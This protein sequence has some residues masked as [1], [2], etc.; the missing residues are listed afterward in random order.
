VTI[1]NIRNQ[2]DAR[3][4]RKERE[5]KNDISTVSQCQNVHRTDE[6]NGGKWFMHPTLEYRV[7]QLRENQQ[8]QPN[9]CF[10][11]GILQHSKYYLYYRQQSQSPLLFV[12]INKVLIKVHLTE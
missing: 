10:D 1:E 6:C 4:E 9:N 3:V 12:P 7:G 2:N 8:V 5:N 11:C